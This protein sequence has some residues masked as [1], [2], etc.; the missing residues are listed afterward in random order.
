MMQAIRGGLAAV[1]MVLCLGGC[2]AR[3][4]ATSSA[5][6]RE[7][8]AIAHA[9][10]QTLADY[11]RRDLSAFCADFTPEVAAHLVRVESTCE[12]DLTPAFAPHPGQ[13]EIYAP[14]ERPNGLRISHVR[15]RGIIAHLTSTW[16]WPDI[17]KTVKLRLQRIHGRWL[18]AT[19]THVVEERLCNRVFGKLSCR[20]F[21]GVRFGVR[22]PPL[23][24]SM[25]P[26]QQ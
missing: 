15:W 26:N 8:P 18:I 7:G 17:R 3:A 21:Y 12:A 19:P 9:V 24:V 11:I 16:P 10:R 1:A 23:I 22:V 5:G 13:E 14:S 20:T 6:R 4:S 2:G 25:E